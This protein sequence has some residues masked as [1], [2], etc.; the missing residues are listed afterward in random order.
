M[1]F[2]KIRRRA[3]GPGEMLGPDERRFAIGTRSIADLIAPAAVEVARDHARLEYQYARVLAVVG[4]PRT[5]SAGWLSPLL[6][7]DQPIELSFHLHPLETAAIVKMLGHKLVQLQSSRLLDDRGGR[8]A[9]PNGRS[10]LRTPSACG[11]RSSVVRS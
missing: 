1:P 7:F 9:T 11:T 3:P 5:V 2:L 10:P 4:Y 6:D 8:L